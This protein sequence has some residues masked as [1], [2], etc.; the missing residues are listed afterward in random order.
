MDEGDLSLS[1]SQESLDG[2]SPELDYQGGT[3]EALYSVG[4]GKGKPFCATKIA[5]KR[6]G[7]S[8]G[9]IGR[10]KGIGKLGYQ[11]R[12]KMTEFGRKRGPKAKMRGIF[13]VP[14]V[15]LQRPMPDSLSKE[16]EPGVENRL[17]LC[18][19]KDKFVLTQD[20]CVMCGA[21][22]TDQEGCLIACAQCGQCYHPYCANVKVTK[23]ILQKGWRC[24]DCTV[25]EGCG[26]RN[27]EARLILCDDCDISYH[28]YCIDPPLD[29]V[30]HGTWKCKWCAQC[31][32]CGSNDPGFNSSW[33][34]SY[35]QCG[36][37][38]SH[39]TCVACQ[40]AYQEGDLIIQCIQCERWLHC[41]CDSIKS[42][43]E[44]ERC[45]QEGYVCLLCRPRDVPPPHLLSKPSPKFS[46]LSPPPQNR[47]PELFK[48][49]SQQYLVDG[50]YLSEAGMNH[51]KSLTSE[52]QQT[53]KKRRK[54]L[55]MVDKEADIMATIESVIAGGSL[56]NSLE[57]N[58]K[59]ELMDV[60]D[61]PETVLKEGMVW[62]Q[63]PP[64]GFSIC[65]SENGLPV[66]RRKRQRNLQKLGI[67]GFVVR[68]RGTRKDKEEEGD[69]EKPGDSSI[70]S[71]GDDK[72]RRKPQRRKPKTKLAECFPLYMQEAFFG[73]DLMDTTKEKDLE[74]SESEEERK[75]P[76]N[77]NTIQLSQDELKAMEQVK[78]KQE[79]ED[80]KIVP[81]Q[82]KRE[83]VMEDDGS[84][85]EAL[86]DII[87]ISGDLLDNDLVNTIMNENDEDLAKASEALDEL[88]DAQG[89]SKDELTDILSPH[90][91]LESMVRDTGKMFQVNI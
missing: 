26:E 12:Q 82:I 77:A 63:P 87:P 8:G 50:V 72:P 18:S 30:P 6:L 54:M 35:T 38:A 5:K 74:S 34:K 69:G 86:G 53:R 39:T 24:L 89:G 75:V 13:G 10:P 73:K 22:G 16:D 76:E 61:E 49:S 36:P 1:A 52:H 70:V 41:I 31:Q 4:L 46:R 57:E 40:D 81:E 64:E 71:M 47:S 88:D 66:L 60:K 42:E 17:V 78:A 14:G 19:A 29:Y 43:T 59:L 20:I 48:P 62:N 67:G 56:D 83:E 7:I 33:Q 3:E 21:I 80:E 65:T 2:E 9:I 44:A 51:I 37:C 55:P 27:D 90:F 11:K 28:I 79:K 84:D 25:C 32:T 85:T 23:V 91:N 45:A 58:N 68:L 15:G